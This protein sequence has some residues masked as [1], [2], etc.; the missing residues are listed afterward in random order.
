MSFSTMKEPCKEGC[1][2]KSP[3]NSVN[4]SKISARRIAYL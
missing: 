3:L 1:R 4:L 2:L